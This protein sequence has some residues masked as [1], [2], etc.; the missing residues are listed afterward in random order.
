MPTAY[1]V[2]RQGRKFPLRPDKQTVV[3]REPGVDLLVDNDSISRRHGAVAG[4][5]GTFFVTDLNSSNGIY[6][7]GSRLGTSPAALKDGDSIRFGSLDF[8]F[9]TS[10]GHLIVPLTAD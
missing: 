9:H 5:D 8:T 1:L 7:N 2:D 4:T 3:G 10:R 6:I